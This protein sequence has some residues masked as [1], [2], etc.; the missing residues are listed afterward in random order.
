MGDVFDFLDATPKDAYDSTAGE[1][2]ILCERT[3]DKLHIRFVKRV[4]TEQDRYEPYCTMSLTG[5]GEDD[6][7]D[8]EDV[9]VVWFVYLARGKEQA[10][11]WVLN[12]EFVLRTAR[13]G[14][15]AQIYNKKTGALLFALRHVGSAIR[16]S[17]PSAGNERV[18]QECHLHRTTEG[19]TVC[20]LCKYGLIVGDVDYKECADGLNDP[21]CFIIQ[22][23][24]RV[25]P[26]SDSA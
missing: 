16:D 15:P 17:A 21:D 18:C 5:S 12:E 14:K 6:A 13:F 2:G 23:Q 26:G 19:E 20:L 4:R 3:L 9:S 24:N 25:N 8:V 11:V 1:H 22:V 7:G 10:L